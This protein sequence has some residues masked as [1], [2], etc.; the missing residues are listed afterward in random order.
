MLERALALLTVVGCAQKR[1][2]PDGP[3]T[4]GDTIRPRLYFPELWTAGRTTAFGSYVE[5]SRPGV[6]K[7]FDLKDDFVL[8]GSVRLSGTIRFF[9]GNAP[10]AEPLALKFAHEC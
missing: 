2:Q 9:A 5:V 4:A 7:S 10:L 8:P 3:P 6:G 1:V